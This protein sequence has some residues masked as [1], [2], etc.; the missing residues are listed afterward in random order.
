MGLFSFA[1]GLKQAKEKFAV[2]IQ[3][4]VLEE[5]KQR[6]IENGKP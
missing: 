2:Q 1:K 3:P 4:D 5:L 6:L